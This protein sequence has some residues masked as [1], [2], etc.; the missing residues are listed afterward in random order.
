MV[1]STR[2]VV[3]NSIS[4]KPRILRRCEW[5]KPGVNRLTVMV[6][7]LAVKHV[8]AML[9]IVQSRLLGNNGLDIRS[10]ESDGRQLRRGSALRPG[11]VVRVRFGALFSDFAGYP[12][13]M[14]HFV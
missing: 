5:V 3:I 6:G 7:I 9:F 10:S 8:L 14:F 4:V 2:M 1:A 11:F 13:R 12:L